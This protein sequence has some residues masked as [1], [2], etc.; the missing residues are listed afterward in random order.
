MKII[1]LHQHFSTPK[2]AVG[3]RSYQMARK[4]LDSGYQVT[5]IC[6]SYGGGETGLTMP[7]RGGRRRGIVDGIEVVEFDLAYSNSTGFLRRAMIFLRFMFSSMWLVLREPYDVAFATTT[8]LTVGVPGLVARWIRRKPFVF[9]VRDL[10]PELPKAMGVITNPFVLATLSALEWA[11]YRSATRLIALSPGIVEGIKNRN[12]ATGSIALIPNGCDLEIF[13]GAA[14]PWRPEG[15]EAADL[16]ALFAG[17]HGNANGLDALLDAALV[18]SRRGRNDIKIVLVGQGREKPFLQK[19]VDRERIDNVIFHDPVD[20]DRL[21]GLMM[22][23]DIG[24]QILANVPAFYYGTSPNKFFD[25]I[26]AGLPVLTNYP[27]WVADLINENDCGF[28][29]EP[30]S[31]EALADAL[32]QAADNRPALKQMGQNAHALAKADFDR[33]VLASRWVDWVA[34]AAVNA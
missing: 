13:S 31:P 11:S 19:R 23:T 12:V 18:L 24:L 33:Q 21:S 25:Y 16:L 20:K 2:G 6:G 15:V 3:I 8:P 10:W 26:A 1:Y 5:M 27:G 29:V 32:E 9:E 4:W 17:T 28:A 7:M 30:V 34:G 22:A 14:A